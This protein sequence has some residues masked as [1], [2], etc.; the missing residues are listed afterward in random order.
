MKGLVKYLG[1]N[2][3]GNILYTLLHI[4]LSKKYYWYEVKFVYRDKTNGRIVLDFKE[5]IGLEHQDTSLDK[6]KVKKI[7]N[8]LHKRE[9]IKRHLCNGTFDC[10]M[11]CYL[12]YFNA[13]N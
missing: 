7:L 10:E 6:R 11:I 3:D 4:I 12:G 13:R 2:R 1:K 9:A 8:P 5:L